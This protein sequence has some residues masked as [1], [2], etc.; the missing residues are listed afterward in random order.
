MT[1]GTV[2][3]GSDGALRWNRA[4]AQLSSP[5]LLLTFTLIDVN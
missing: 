2:L 4:V 3:V 1:C 5:L